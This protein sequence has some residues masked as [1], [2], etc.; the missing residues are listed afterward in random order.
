[1]SCFRVPCCLV[2]LLFCFLLSG[3]GSYY[4]VSADALRADGADIYSGSYI[5][6]PGNDET[7]ALLFRE[8]AGMVEHAFMVRGFNVTDDPA[9]ARNV[10]HL[11]YWQEEPQ[12]T[13]GTTVEWRTVPVVVR[14]GK[15][16]RVVYTQVEEFVPTSWTTYTVKMLIEAF[17]KGDKGQPLWKT[18]LS[19]SGPMNNPRVLLARMA[20]VLPHII[21]MQTPGVVSFEVKV[22]ENGQAAVSNVRGW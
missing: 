12:V 3:C 4:T 17:E 5:L 10:A 8:V 6:E 15:K 7:D 1:M 9:Q 13:V 22:D 18:L 14:D 11:S 21:G 16:S 2:A 20:P 19:C